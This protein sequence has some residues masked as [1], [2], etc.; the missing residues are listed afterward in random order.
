MRG[1]AGRGKLGW[2][3]PSIQ[4]PQRTAR[5]SGYQEVRPSPFPTRD[6]GAL[7]LFLSGAGRSLPPSYSLQREGRV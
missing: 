1:Q 5:E 2:F 7:T 6:P 3:P 4:Y